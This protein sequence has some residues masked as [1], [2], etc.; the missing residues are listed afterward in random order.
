MLRLGLASLRR[1]KARYVTTVLAVVLGVV[2]VTGT[3]VFSDTL[4]SS[5]ESTV[6]G[7][8]E[9]LDAV[10]HS[11]SD[12][13]RDHEP[14]AAAV[15]EDIR[16]L[17]EVEA[18][19]GMLVGRAAVLDDQGRA[20]G[21]AAP[22]AVS[23]GEVARLEAAKGRLPQADDEAALAE[24][25]AE[26][27]DVEIGDTLSVV[28][29]EAQS[30][31]LSVVGMVDV[32]TETELSMS[33]T[34]VYTE[35]TA[36]ML[37]GVAEG[38]HELGVLGAEG[39]TDA[40]VAAAVEEAAGAGVLIRTGEEFG[41]ALAEAAGAD[42]ELLR[43]A[44]LLFAV[45]S[46]FV[47]GIVIY[48]TFAILIAQRQR[49][50]AMLR[51]LGSVRG[52]VFRAVLI[53]A[54]AVGKLVAGPVSKNLVHVFHLSESARKAS[55]ADPDRV[56]ERVAVLGAG[57]MGG[58]IAQLCAYRELSVRLKDIQ[59]AA[60]GQGLRHARGLFDRQVRRG[61]MERRDAEQAMGRISP[62]L[63]YSGFRTVD[64]V[65]EAIVEDLAIKERVLR[66]VEEHVGDECVLASNTSSI[67]VSRLQ[68]GL[69]RPERVCGMHFFNPVHRMPLVEVV[70]GEQTSD[71][72]LA[73]VFALAR[74]LGKTPIIVNDGAGFLVNRILA[75][76]LNEA[77]WLIAE[78]AE[79]E[80][81]D[82]ALVEFGMPMG[83]LRLLDEVGFDVA[84]HVARVMHEAFGARMRPAQPLEALA[85]TGRS[86][87][88]GGAGFYRYENGKEKS[89]DE[90]IYRELG[91]AAA[92]ERRVFSPL[93]VV[94]RAM[95]AMVNEAAHALEDGIVADGGTVDLGMIMG[96]G[97]PPFRGGLLRWAD[98][99]GPAKVLER[100]EALAAEHGERFEPA[101]LLRARVEAGAGFY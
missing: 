54:A 93:E 44:L 20:L 87:R 67:P 77:G 35:D 63:D 100:L 98:D 10:V 90:S 17:A 29:P 52:Q 96:T 61:R 42:V 60:I 65:I 64:V 7:S 15:L 48:N 78:G 38:F 11:E 73:R 8:A 76:Y 12:G 40:E 85:R 9:N 24:S 51:C 43:V 22:A 19:S 55:P 92:A 68:M 45:V 57:V 50:L 23:L 18:A 95:L 49:D 4:E 37:S 99:R 36:R 5:F 30:H 74:N 2:F 75:P 53:E 84:A 88:K 97:F 6:M 1:Y 34:V 56:P 41:A 28:D 82:R 26:F 46:M 71:A 81:V 69:R 47:A 39:H 101:P 89:A 21:F 32:G 83:P 33:G 58:G 62:T 31:D 72:T 25:L 27:M 91:E 79:I 14:V 66:E 70:R 13:L 86:G 94:D 59:P 3:M 16:E 80:H